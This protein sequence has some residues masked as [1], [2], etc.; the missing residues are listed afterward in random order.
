M[1]ENTTTGPGSA[2]SA[3]IM[4]PVTFSLDTSIIDNIEKMQI[5]L[6]ALN[7]TMSQEQYDRAEPELQAIFKQN[8]LSAE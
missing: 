2:S 1:E 7:L 8:E 5:V 6:K 3:S 4:P